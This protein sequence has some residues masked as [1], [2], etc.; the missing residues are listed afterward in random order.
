MLDYT[1]SK[2]TAHQIGKPPA[3]GSL[4]TSPGQESWTTDKNIVN[5]TVQLRGNYPTD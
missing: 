5:N 2:Q 3:T 4:V 1:F